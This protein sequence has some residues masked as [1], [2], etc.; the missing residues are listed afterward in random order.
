MNFWFHCWDQV[1][2][3]KNTPGRHGRDPVNVET[4]SMQRAGVASRIPQQD[5]IDDGF[6]DV[7]YRLSHI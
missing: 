7:N 5:G 4:L 2:Q 1:S 6:E 3:V